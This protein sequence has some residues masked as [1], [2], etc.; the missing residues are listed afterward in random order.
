YLDHATARLGSGD[1]A[2]E[3]GL[4]LQPDDGET[5]LA[6]V[7]HLYS[8]LDYHREKQELAIAQHTLPNSSELFELSGLIERREGHWDESTHNL[9]KVLEIDPLN[10]FTLSQISTNYQCLRR[11]EQGAEVLDRTLAGAPKDVVTRFTRAQVDLHWRAD[12][13]SLP[14]KL[15]A[16]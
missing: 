4:R 2:V 9:E 7:R 5:H 12:P 16:I 11:Y 10:F 13:K 14:T 15:N 3:T 6:V 8:N 1:A